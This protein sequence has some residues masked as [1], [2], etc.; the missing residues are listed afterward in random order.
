MKVDQHRD[1]A[2]IEGASASLSEVMPTVTRKRASASRLRSI[3]F[4]AR[5][6]GGV[7]R[8]DLRSSEAVIE[9]P[10]TS[11]SHHDE[12]AAL[13]EKMKMLMDVRVDVEK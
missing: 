6:A 4:A 13:E 8:L 1:S 10:K 11:P 9:F 12:G 7:V 5:D 2:A 3:L